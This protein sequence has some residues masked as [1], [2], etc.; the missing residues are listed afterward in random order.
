MN[1]DWTVNY[2]RLWKDIYEHLFLM[3]VST[4]YRD[5][6]EHVSEQARRYRTKYSLEKRALREQEN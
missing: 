1:D 4:R 5:F 6:H 2:R 3:E